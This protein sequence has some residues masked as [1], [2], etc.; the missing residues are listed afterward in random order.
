MRKVFVGIGLAALLA[1]CG[2]S[3]KTVT[4]NKTA[5]ETTTATATTPANTTTT[6][7]APSNTTENKSGWPSYT[8]DA[9]IDGC[10]KGSSS[11]KSTC[12]CLADELQKHFPTADELTSLLAKG[13]DAFT[14]N[15]KVKQAVVE[16]A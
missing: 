2:G 9:F 10:T 6:A 3:T 13:E 5:T 4:E 1:G 11:D 16:C 15:S 8:R 12:T 14:S 7:T